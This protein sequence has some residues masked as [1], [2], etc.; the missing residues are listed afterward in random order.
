MGDNVCDTILWVSNGLGQD[1]Y[2]SCVF[3]RT[4]V[5]VGWPLDEFRAENDS[6]TDAGL[7]DSGRPRIFSER[8]RTRAGLVP[9][10]EDGR[11]CRPGTS[12]RSPHEPFWH[13]A[14]PK[15]RR[16]LRLPR[17][18]VNHEGKEERAEDLGPGPFSG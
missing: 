5:S 15:G 12:P 16:W 17:S 14:E 18:S 10:A 7:V 4:L 13:I 1:Y 6:K 9:R 8:N 2:G 3:T 11:A